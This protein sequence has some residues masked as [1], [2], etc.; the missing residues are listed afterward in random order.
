MRATTYRS[1]RSISA[2]LTPRVSARARPRSR[3][4]V[5]ECEAADPRRSRGNRGC[6][7]R[8]TGRGGPSRPCSPRE[9]PPELGLDRFAAVVPLDPVPLVLLTDLAHPTPHEPGSSCTE[10][11][12]ERAKEH[13][14]LDGEELEDD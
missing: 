1:G 3:R 6:E 10:E 8:R 14:P 5:C 7:R 4:P 9:Y 2:M 13:P 11:A 12:A